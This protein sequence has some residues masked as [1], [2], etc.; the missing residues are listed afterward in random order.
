MVG[1]VLRR[2]VLR[3]GWPLFHLSE[4]CTYNRPLNNRFF[5]IIVGCSLRPHEATRTPGGGGRGGGVDDT[6]YQVYF[7]AV[8]TFHYPLVSVFFQETRGQP[9]SRGRCGPGGPI[10]IC[11]NRV[12]RLSFSPIFVFLR[13]SKGN[14]RL[15]SRCSCY[16]P[17][18]F[19]L[20][21][22][23]YLY[24]THLGD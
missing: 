9:Q 1:R 12:F 5:D 24:C 14:T 23:R 20:H 17:V 4:R 3:K 21:R 19:A 2:R 15:S 6:I 22:L 11:L 8:F 16:L 7:G 13:L 18:C 10:Y